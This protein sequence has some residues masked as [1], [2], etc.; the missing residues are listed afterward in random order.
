MVGA[1]NVRLLMMELN[2]FCEI[3]N[4][5]TLYIMW[6]YQWLDPISNVRFTMVRL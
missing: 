3:T 1:C 5:R 6:D 4:S 2:R